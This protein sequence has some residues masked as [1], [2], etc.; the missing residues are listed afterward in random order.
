M[1]LQKRLM[2]LLCLM[3]WIAYPTLAQADL[4][5]VLPSLGTVEAHLLL[6]ETFDL[7]DAWE[8][9]SN[10]NGVELGV[11]N[12]VY[13]AYTMNEG[14]VW[15]LNTQEH[16]DV[17]LEVE[18]TP[19]TINFDNGYGVMCRADT[20]NNGDGYYFMINA[21]GYYSIRIGQGSDI[22]PLVDWTQS[23]AIRTEIDQN[24]IGA[25]CIDDNLAMYVN[26]EV[27]AEVTDETYASGYAGLTIAAAANSE[28]D[29][30]FDNLML[31]AITP[32]SLIP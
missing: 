12:G 20:A 27:L 29:I 22:L 7:E 25:A 6:V 14:F 10:P 13:R 24:T 1:I 9:Y 11:A 17:V 26:G 21:N 8:E 5:L 28:T 19:L 3:M 30:A 32:S 18:A 23:D 15:G 31:Y 4:R 2:I 16:T